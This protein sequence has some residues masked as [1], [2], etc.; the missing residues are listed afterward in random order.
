VIADVTLTAIVLVQK[1]ATSV[2][3]GLD[4]EISAQIQTML[5]IASLPNLR[6]LQLICLIEEIND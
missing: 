1:H 3:G 5:F 2:V 6:V 4:T